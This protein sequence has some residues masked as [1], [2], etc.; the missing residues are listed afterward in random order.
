MTEVTAWR[1]VDSDMRMLESESDI[2]SQDDH[3]V[4]DIVEDNDLDF[5]LHAGITRTN[6]VNLSLQTN[7]MQCEEIAPAAICSYIEIFSHFV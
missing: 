4:N 5:Q 1:S 6:F 3:I 2:N 7:I